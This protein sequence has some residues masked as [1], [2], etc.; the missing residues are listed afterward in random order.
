MANIAKMLELQ[1][2]YIAFGPQHH[3]IFPRKS[4]TEMKKSMT[5]MEKLIDSD[6]L[7]KLSEEE[8][9]EVEQFV[10]C[11]FSRLVCANFHSAD[12]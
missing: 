6:F 11:S 12:S 8:R 7:Q 5:D 4:K 1:F 2:I 3:P 10:G 9:Q